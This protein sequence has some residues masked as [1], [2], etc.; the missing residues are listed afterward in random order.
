MLEGSAVSGSF[1]FIVGL[2]NS[3]ILWRV[4]AKRRRVSTTRLPPC[5]TSG[6]TT[7]LK[8]KKERQMRIA[9]GEDP[10]DVDEDLDMRDAESHGNTLMMKLIGPIVT[11]VDRPWKMYPVG[12][13]FGFGGCTSPA[14][15]C[16]GC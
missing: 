9:R 1:L 14:L 7:L 3:I 12:V 16:T 11:F 2:A 6:L 13:L 8:I 4:L 15:P 10:E 5:P